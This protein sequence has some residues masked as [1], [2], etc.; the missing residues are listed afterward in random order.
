MRVEKS[1][2]VLLFAV[3][4]TLSLVLAGCGGGEPAGEEGSGGEVIEWS[5]YSPYGPEDS[6]C[7]R[8]WPALFEQIEEETNGQLVIT[9]Y[10]SGQHPY[11]GE[12]MLRVIDEG[13]AELA[14]FYGGYIASVE[15]VLAVDALPLLFPSD[16]IEA[17]AVTSA[18]WGDFS[19]NTEG[20]LEKVLEENWG[21]SMIHMVPA[22]SQRLMTMDYEAGAIG[23]LTGHK[24]RT[25]SAEFGEFVQ[26]LGGT[27]VTIS[28]SEVYTSLATNLI[29]G[30]ITSV[31]FADAGGYFDYVNTINMWEI[32]QSSDGLMVSMEAL[33]SLPDEVKEVFLRVMYDSATKPEM[34]E[35]EENDTIVEAKEASGEVTIVVP[36]DEERAQVSAIMSEKIWT[37]WESK[38]GEAGAAVLEQINEMTGK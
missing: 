18:L 7:C 37:P 5:F 2:W 29:D 12:D 15:P 27:P 16:P 30:L 24:I 3:V 25:Y 1:K 8:I 35:I 21:A 22:T 26:A 33:N 6:A 32:T 28:A 9:T 31:V 10:W 19:Q 13:A 4:M 20:A 14:H 17:W 11:S 38:T 34:L 23:S 36:S